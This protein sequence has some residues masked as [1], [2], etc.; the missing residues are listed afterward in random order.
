MRH[1]PLHVAI[2]WSLSHY[3]PL[4]GFH[5][6]YRALFDHV[7]ENVR[8]SAWDN[9]KLYRK[10]RNEISVRGE[11]VEKAERE[12]QRLDRV[13]GSSVAKRYRK[14][15][16]PP[17]HVLTTA[18]DGDLEFHHTAPFPSLRRPFVFHCE[19]FAPIFSRSFSKAAAMLKIMRNSRIIIEV[20]LRILC[21]SESFL[22]CPTR[23]M[24]LARSCRT[25]PSTGSCF[26]QGWG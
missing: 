5:P 16:W 9:V 15:F 24:P 17:D 11:V 18:L 1:S 21:A 10:F 13:D 20:F 25:R 19:S 8:L 3:I 6:L 7:P 23:F 2:P 12:G 4:G 22:M 14:Y 26:P